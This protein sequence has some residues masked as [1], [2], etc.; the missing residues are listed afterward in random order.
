MAFCRKYTKCV[1]GRPHSWAPWTLP[2][3]V[4]RLTA[5][6]SAGPS[7]LLCSC[8]FS[9]GSQLPSFPSAP[10]QILLLIPSLCSKRTLISQADLSI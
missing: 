2:G 3:E 5:H 9:S 6:V 8:G 4:A 7:G 10:V 1:I